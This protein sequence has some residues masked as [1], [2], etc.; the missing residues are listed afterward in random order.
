MERLERFPDVASASKAFLALISEG[1][2]TLGSEDGFH[3]SM[4]SLWNRLVG[5]G[6]A[7]ARERGL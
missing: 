6:P 5:G 4:D 2:Q 1:K 3:Q 7:R